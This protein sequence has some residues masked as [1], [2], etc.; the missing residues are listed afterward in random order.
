MKQHGI[1]GQCLLFAFG[2][3]LGW[4]ISAL[5]LS[6]YTDVLSSSGEP[7]PIGTMARSFALM[8]V[9]ISACFAIW[10]VFRSLLSRRKY[11]LPSAHPVLLGLACPAAGLSLAAL[12]GRVLQVRP[13]LAH[14]GGLLAACLVLPLVAAEVAWRS[15]RR[16]AQPMPLGGG[17]SSL[18][19]DREP[20]T[21]EGSR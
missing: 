13:D 17:R 21:N 5:V 3:W 18:G 9:P 16:A 14:A 8:S 20:D 1:L 19:V 2:N 12:L 4:T 7:M 10:I 6:R 11:S 15:G